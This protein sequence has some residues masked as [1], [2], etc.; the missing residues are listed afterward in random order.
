MSGSGAGRRGC[1]KCAERGTV[2]V[3]GRYRAKEV[4]F[5]ALLEIVLAAGRYSTIL[6]LA[7]L[8]A[9]VLGFL[10]CL[11]ALTDTSLSLAFFNQR[12]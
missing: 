10:F 3:V 12:L 4:A 11:A 9:V 1:A 2:Q 6:G 7:T 5:P 8:R